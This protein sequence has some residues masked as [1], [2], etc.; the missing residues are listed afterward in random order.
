MKIFQY[1]FNFIAMSF[2]WNNCVMSIIKP[3]VILF[4]F[5]RRHVNFIAFISF[6]VYMYASVLCA[7]PMNTT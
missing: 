6:F 3:Y 5:D 7:H 4:S 1:L 2:K